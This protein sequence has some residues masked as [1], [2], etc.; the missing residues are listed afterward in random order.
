MRAAHTAINRYLPQTLLFTTSS[1][2]TQGVRLGVSSRGWASLRSIPKEDAMFVEDD[3]ELITFDFVTEPSTVD[4]FLV[5]LQR[6]Y[7]GSIVGGR[8]PDQSKMVQ[9]AHLGHGVCSHDNITRLP[10]VQALVSHMQMLQGRTVRNS[11]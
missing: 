1:L 5:P 7:N 3:F 10:K 6:L 8:I 11:V 2:L 4:A 9:I